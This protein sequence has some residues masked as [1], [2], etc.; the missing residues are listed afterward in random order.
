MKKVYMAKEKEQTTPQECEALSCSAQFATLTNELKHMREDIKELVNYIKT[1]FKALIDLELNQLREELKRADEEVKALQ[2][3]V[4][5]LE[6]RVW[7]IFGA[8]SALIFVINFVKPLV[9]SWIEK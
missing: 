6:I 4:A 9:M 1:D 7:T 2:E 8:V 5:K 3:R